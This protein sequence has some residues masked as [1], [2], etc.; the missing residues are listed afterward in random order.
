MS[1]LEKYQLVNSCETS[2]E[3]ASAIL[4][5]ADESGEIMG[6]H[7]PFSAEKM[8]SYVPIVINQGANPNLLTREFGIRQQALY[9]TY[10]QI[11][12]MN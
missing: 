6:R 7:R 1:E 3:L 11:T 10:S 2:D 8:A 4:Q 5:L 12:K 9:I